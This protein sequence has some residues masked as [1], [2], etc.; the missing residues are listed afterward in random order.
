MVYSV[1]GAIQMKKNSTKILD[2]IVAAGIVFFTVF[3]AF[4][5][6]AADRNSG[7]SSVLMA[8]LQIAV[9]AV[10]V[11]VAVFLS[12]KAYHLFC[13]ILLALCGCVILVDM[14]SPS[15]YTMLRLWPV[16]GLVSGVALL[17]S[18]RFRYGKF[19]PGFV[20]P[21]AAF[22]LCGLFFMLFS[23]DIIKIPFRVFFSV[24]GPVLAVI[25]CAAIAAVFFIQKK[26]RRLII[27]GEEPEVFDDEGMIF[28]DSGE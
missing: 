17:V 7:V 12:G 25:V 20:I 4:V 9:G 8:V 15:P 3:F 2:F 10:F 5:L 28:D 22:V 18:G 6:G 21:S 23:F 11:A 14:C 13:G 27:D 26:K 19:S 24:A 1:A 16:F